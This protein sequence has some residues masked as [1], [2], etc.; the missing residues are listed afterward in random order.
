MK[1]IPSQN[2]IVPAAINAELMS[3]I[4]KLRDALIDKWPSNV[5]PSEK[6]R[7]IGTIDQLIF[8]FEHHSDIF[9]TDFN[10]SLLFGDRIQPVNTVILRSI[11]HPQ[12]HRLALSG[13]SLQIIIDEMKPLDFKLGELYSDYEK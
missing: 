9:T 10:Y 3:K 5:F 6:E 7:F 12:T 11:S 8:S 1:T 13:E 4:E 2:P